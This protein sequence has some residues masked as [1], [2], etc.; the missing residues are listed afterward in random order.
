MN[1]S[2][3]RVSKSIE[4]TMSWFDQYIVY[5]N[6]MRTNSSVTAV[7]SEENNSSSSNDFSTKVA[8]APPMVFGVAQYNPNYQTQLP[9]LID[10]MLSKGAQG[11]MLFI[12]IV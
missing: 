5:H 4:R 8:I 9:L 3:K 11:T 2:K 1:E 6:N 12:F 7:S 10:N